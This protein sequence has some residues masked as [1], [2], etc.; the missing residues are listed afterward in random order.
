MYNHFADALSYAP[1]ISLT[2]V[3]YI[4]RSGDLLRLALDGGR[5]PKHD[6][7]V[8]R[9]EAHSLASLAHLL[10]SDGLFVFSL[11]QGQD[12][13]DG[14]IQA[15][16]QFHDI[17][18]SFGDKTAA[19]LSANK[20]LQGVIVN[21]LCP[22]LTPIPT[23]HISQAQSRN[24]HRKGSAAS[25][26]PVRPQTEHARRILSHGVERPAIDGR[27]SCLFRAGRTV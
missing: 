12:G 27:S 18:G 16:A 5:L 11:L 2:F 13:E 26:W 19:M 24:R 20:Y 21:R 3:Y 25:Y 22:E 23:V 10:K 6:E 1:D 9:A 4:T 17:L 15:L 14:Q 8:S 7:L